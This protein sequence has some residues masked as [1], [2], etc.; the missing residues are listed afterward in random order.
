VAK[1]QHKPTSLPLLL[2]CWRLHSRPMTTTVLVAED[3]WVG[4]PLQRRLPPHPEASHC[5]RGLRKYSQPLRVPKVRNS[6]PFWMTH[7]FHLI[8]N[9]LLQDPNT[10]AVVGGSPNVFVSHAWS[11]KF[12]DVVQALCEFADR[13]SE[14]V[15][16]FF[17]FDC[18]CIDEY[19]TQVSSP[20][21][22]I[23]PSRPRSRAS[24]TRS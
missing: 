1:Q 16:V 24:A 12:V 10:V 15:D 13:Q 22:G 21:F 4:R 18:L 23:P 5:R 14:P 3:R 8:F 17:S 20:T 6:T 9:V 2:C 11:Y 7:A 19:A